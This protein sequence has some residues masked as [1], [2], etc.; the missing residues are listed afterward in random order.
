M[1]KLVFQKI[2]SDYLL[3]FLISLLSSSLIVWIFQA[4]NYLDLMVEDG[5]GYLTY[6]NYSLLNFPKIISRLLPFV[7]FFSFF[8]ILNN[9]EKTNELLI[10][11]NFGINKIHLIY[12]FFNISLSL[13]IFQLFLTSYV[14]PN[15]LK[16]S[17]ELMNNSNL[18]FFEGFIK[19]KKFN[20]TIKGVTIYS[21]D[22]ND[23]GDLSNIFVKKNVGK[24]SFQITHAKTGK[25]KVGYNNILELYDGETINSINNKITKFKFLKSDFSLNNAE[26]NAV[27]YIKLQETPTQVILSCVNKIFKINIK[28]LNN[29]E[30]K[31]YALGC[32][33]NSLDNIFRELYKRFIIPLYIPIL[34]L[35]TSL[36]LTSS[37]EEKKYFKLKIGVFLINFLIIIFSETSIKLISNNFFKNLSLVI[38]PIILIF[39]IIFCFAYNLKLKF[40]KT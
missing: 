37:K 32:N 12:F 19:P 9:Y 36:L 29:V 20:D 27:Q 24:N 3:F 21:E 26:S 10:F 39:I 31:G 13:M 17:K 15:S 11:W 6:I 4:V 16:Y 38:T 30:T 22:K 40:S 14:V 35:L 8:F 28:F 5:K 25:L 7:L 34:I 1:N 33:I 23:N 2:L 18:N